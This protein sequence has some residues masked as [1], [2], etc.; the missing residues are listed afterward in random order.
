MLDIKLIDNINNANILDVR[1]VCKLENNQWFIKLMRVTN[2]ASEEEKLTQVEYPTH[3]FI[4]RKMNNT[5]FVNFLELFNDEGMLLLDGIELHHKKLRLDPNPNHV[6]GQT[7][8]WLT[9]NE[10]PVWIYKGNW[11]DSSHDYYQSSQPL[12]GIG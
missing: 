6:P 12:I 4:R 11:D 7:K 8:W 10:M 2:F 3:L 5:E 1:L 9:K